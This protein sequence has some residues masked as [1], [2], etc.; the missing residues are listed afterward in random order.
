MASSRYFVCRVPFC[1]TT[2]AVLL[3][4]LLSGSAFAAKA[5]ELSAIE[6]YPTGESQAYVQISGFTL[7]GKNE[8]H[9]CTAGQPI[10]KNSYGKLPKLTLAPN[11]SIERAKDGV[12]LLSRGGAPECVVPA[13]LKLEKAEGVTPSELADKTD[14]QGQ[15]VGKSVGSAGTIPPLTPGVKIVLVSTLDT[16][17]AEF[18]LAQR[19]ESIAGWKSFL[20]KYP[21][22]QHT[23]E[24][25]GT[26]AHLYVLN[27]QSQLAAYETSLK[28]G[29]PNYGKLQ[30]AR[31]ALESANALVPSSPEMDA[32]ATGINAETSNLNGKGQSEIALYRDALVKQVPG[33]SHLVAAETISQLT[34]GLDPKSPETASLSQA[35][36]REPI[37][38]IVLSTLPISY[39]PAGPRR[40]MRPSSPFFHSPANIPGSTTAF[41]TYIPTMSS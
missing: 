5:P 19:S 28:S 10:N 17:L 33:Y 15:V 26:L 27:G 11:W 30:A 37:S 32:L 2:V 6:V 18:L 1:R 40:L 22:S 31:A 24:G 4:G 23:G 39:P 35:C 8:V 20:G 21:S 36:I 38:I 34:L 3:L 13:N 25:K 29:Q 14:L 41:T 12:L 16:E 9:L 7:N